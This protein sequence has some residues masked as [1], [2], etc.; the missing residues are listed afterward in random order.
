MAAPRSAN[1]RSTVAAASAA[2]ADGAAPRS[3]H[4]R[5]ARAA[6]S[7]TSRGAYY[8]EALAVIAGH[9]GSPY[10]ALYVRVGAEVIEH[11]WHLGPG[12]PALWKNPAQALLTESLARPVPRVKL[13]SGKNA[14]LKLGLLTTPLADGHGQP[15]GA[16]V[17]VARV[18]RD[19]AAAVSKELHGL[20]ALLSALQEFVGAP[21]VVTGSTTGAVTPA[22][23]DALGRAAAA[24]SVE[25]LAFAITNN[26]RNKLDCEHVALGLVQ[27]RR[28][29]PVSISGLDQIAP[30]SP[31]VVEI[32]AAME[33]CLDAGLPL[34]SDGL[35]GVE[36]GP[37]GRL[38]AQ[39]QRATRGAAVATLPLCAQGKPIAIVALRRRGATPFS[40]EE[41]D[42]IARLIG[43]HVAALPLLQVARRSALRHVRD[44]LLQASAQLLRP[45]HWGRK[46]LIVAMVALAG[47]C[48]FGTLPYRVASPAAIRPGAQR[49]LSMPFDG[50]AVAA[51]RRAGEH[52][53]RGDVLCV[54]DAR[55]LLQERAAAVAEIE[56]AEREAD[57]ARAGGAPDQ[58]ALAGTRRELARARLALVEDRLRHV[59]VRSPFD[60][61]IV[62]GDLSVR[63]G[64]RLAQGETLFAVAPE[65]ACRLELELP[66]HAVTQVRAGQ[67]G[68]FVAAARPEAARTFRL[69]RVH[70]ASSELATGAVFRA[71]ADLPGE[72]EWLRPGME[73]VARVDVGAR[74]V[75][76]IAARRVMD[77]LRMN[78][79]L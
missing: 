34:S 4:L 9:F 62:S 66:E 58:A 28:V 55:S 75:W 35:G 14:D 1:S 25:Q 5:I 36:R 59:E 63:L 61:V 30:R 71:E 78:F 21:P 2:Q 73:G 22:H 7:A 60:G 56:L 40:R 51:P 10:A 47:W 41:L 39:W 53:S 50:V 17:L 79:W 15:H 32:V 38:H 72:A 27:G 43:P 31:G 23:A 49:I 46:A 12:D 20:A 8:R 18:A 69:T 44:D 16:L 11:D 68:R 19:D 6:R 33:E 37:H 64:T 45:G 52:V 77:Y 76:W 74:P 24:E 42:R 48:A 65:G 29:R 57:I 70:A 67:S 13:L 3:A 26:L 54:L